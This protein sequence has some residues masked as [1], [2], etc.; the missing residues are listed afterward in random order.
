MNTLSDAVSAAR[1][2]HHLMRGRCS[3]CAIGDQPYN[4]IHK[5]RYPCG[6]EDT[7]I[8]CHGDWGLEYGDQCQACGRIEKRNALSGF[9]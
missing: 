1:K 8:L 2:K 3:M 7:C 6:N 4:G 9:K 5:G